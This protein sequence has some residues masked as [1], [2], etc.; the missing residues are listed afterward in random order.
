MGISTL[1]NGVITFLKDATPF[2]DWVDCYVVVTYDGENN[3]FYW[4]GLDSNGWKIDLRKEVSN[5]KPKDVYHSNSTNF[6]P[7][8]TVGARDN[9]VIYKEGNTE[10]I[11]QTPSNDVSYADAVRCFDLE[12]LSDGTY[13]IVGYNTACGTDVGVPSS[14]DG[15]PVTIIGE[16]AFK[17]KGL[18]SVV[19]YYGIK[20]IMNGA[21]QNNSITDVKLSA[22]VKN[23]G[24][25]A[26]YNNKIKSLDLPD[27]IERIETYGFASN[28]ITSISFPKTLTYLGSYAF[29]NNKLT[30]ID[31]KSNPSLGGAAFSNNSM[32]DSSAII[33]KFNATTGETDYRTIVGYAGQSKDVVIP[34]SVNG[35]APLYIN[36]SAFAS[37]YLTSVSIPDSVTH[38]YDAA[39]YNNSLTSI[40]LPKNLVYIGGQAFRANYIK[41]VEIPTGVSTIGAAAFTTNCF[42]SGQDIIYKHN[43][44]G[45]WDYSTIVSNG[46]G[47]CGVSTITI[48][49]VKNG[50]KLK[51]IIGGAFQCG[52]YT[53]ITLPN[54]SQTDHLTIGVNA[55]YQNNLPKDQGFFY[56]IS[57]GQYDYSIIDSYGGVRSGEIVI[58]GEKNG[59]KLTSVAASFQWTGFTKITIPS[60]VTY[61][62]NSTFCRSNSNNTGLRTIVN[63]TGRAFNW[64]SLTCSSHANPDGNF[65]T[66]TVSHQSGDVNIVAN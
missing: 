62:G 46:S 56:R 16:N 4:T 31:L 29:Y 65:V 36:S 19:L 38:I 64:Y 59:V 57:N 6:I 2:G 5:L 3:H 9:I 34:P 14:V 51:S 26:F 20:E 12:A 45:T 15:K 25:W 22:T 55:F 10:A 11:E 24:P 37:C 27:G 53:S 66:G 21:F 40:K 17:N 43:S 47:R 44:N 23:I 28:Q 48:P 58:P 39:F 1:A 8:N 18:T 42:P 41:S 13:S 52:Y 50:V 33:Y 61:L 32:P 60:T 7:G 54:L 35:V 49:A 30:E 63:K